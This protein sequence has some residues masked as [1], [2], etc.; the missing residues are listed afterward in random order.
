MVSF[1]SG[2]NTEVNNRSEAGFGAYNDSNAN[3]EISINTLFS[4]GNGAYDNRHN[5]LEIKK[6]G[7]VYIPDTDDTTSANYYEK[8]MKRLQD[9][10]VLDTSVSQ[11]W[12]SSTSGSTDLTDYYTKS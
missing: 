7:D 10:F 5:A 3:S 11:L 9:L 4:V 1:A 6:N 12:D 8:P 2:E